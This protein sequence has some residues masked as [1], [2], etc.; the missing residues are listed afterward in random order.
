MVVNG[1]AILYMCME[2]IVCQSDRSPQ[3]VMI[4][5]TTSIWEPQISS[6]GRRNVEKTLPTF[7]VGFAI[8]ELPHFC[9]CQYYS[10][11]SELM[12]YVRSNQPGL[13]C[14]PLVE[15]CSGQEQ[16]YI[17]SAWYWVS[18]WVR[19]TFSQMYPPVEACSGLWQYYIRS[20]WHMVKLWSGWSLLRCNIPGS[21]I[22]WPRVVLTWVLLIW[23]QM[24]CLFNMGYS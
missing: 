3:R 20:A 6:G 15:A 7:G 18:I 9:I 17:R 5:Q 1:C 13:R 22:W 19:L 2:V 12:Y 21:G 23:A 10:Y 8:F 4:S 16:Y 24:Y 11:G 14:T